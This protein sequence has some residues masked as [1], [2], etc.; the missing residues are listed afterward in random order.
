MLSWNCCI[1][2]S[3]FYHTFST[4]REFCNKLGASCFLRRWWERMA[5]KL[6]QRVLH[7][8][9]K[10]LHQL[11]CRALPYKTVAAAKQDRQWQSSATVHHSE[12]LLKYFELFWILDACQLCRMP[13]QFC[14]H[15][16]LHQM[17][18]LFCLA[19]YTC[20][21]ATETSHLSSV[22][23]IWAWR[24]KSARGRKKP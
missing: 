8:Q 14:F 17:R 19:L 6:W 18:L 1:Y 13:T 20:M 9:I 24:A 23:T 2:F 16:L 10:D 11:S 22:S 15:N 21:Q 7:C 3:D 5:C 4:F 12:V